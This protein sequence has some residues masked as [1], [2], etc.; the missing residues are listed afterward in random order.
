MKYVKLALGM[1]GV[2]VAAFLLLLVVRVGM[3][4]MRSGAQMLE[5]WGNMPVEEVQ[6]TAPTLPPA[7]VLTEDEEET[8]QGGLDS[9]LLPEESYGN[10]VYDTEGLDLFEV[11]VESVA[12]DLPPI[13]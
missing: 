4:L 1:A 8:V 7:P 6:E 13:E 11:P 5:A 10:V 2:L 3:A 9:D 12:E